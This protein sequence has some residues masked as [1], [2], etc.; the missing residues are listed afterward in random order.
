MRLI[1]S[2]QQV[3]CIVGAARCF[4]RYMLVSGTIESQKFAAG[5]GCAAG[6]ALA[7]REI[8]TLNNTFSNSATFFLVADNVKNVLNEILKLSDL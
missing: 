7:C 1:A 8:L 4:R 2:S 3:L 6:A 5:T